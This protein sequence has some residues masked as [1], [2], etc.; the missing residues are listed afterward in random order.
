MFL[1][2]NGEKISKSRGNGL[3]ID[4]WLTYAS[5]ESLQLFMYQSPG[6][7]KR[8]FF[9][10]I[11]RTVDEYLGHLAKVRDQDPEARLANPVWFIHHGGPPDEDVPVTFAMLLNLVSACNTDDREVLWGFL[12]RYAPEAAPGT[13]P[14][15]D[16]MVGYAIRYYRD[17]VLPTKAHRAPDANEQKALADL[18]IALNRIPAGAAP[19]EI[20]SEVYE[21]GRANGYENLRDWFKTL[22]EVLFGQSQGP[23]MGS[24]I[25]LYGVTETIDLIRRARDGQL[26][27]E[28]GG[29]GGATA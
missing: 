15:L 24:V 20:Q 3:T 5:P 2:E 11:P 29:S 22:Y 23:R 19:E 28:P 10:I 13:N 7:A 26:A 8:L 16:Q 6:R 1:D 18:V 4:E 9:D 12:S 17:F 27:G 25:A 14:I 21:V